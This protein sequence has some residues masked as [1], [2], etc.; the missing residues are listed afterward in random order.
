MIT[1]IEYPPC[2][3]C[4]KAK[5]WLNDESVSFM[6]RHIVNDTPSYDELKQWIVYSKLP[7]KA[8]F[9]TSGNVYKSL[10][11]KDK[12]VNMDDDEKILLLSQNGML[13]KRPILVDQTHVIVGYSEEKYSKYFKKA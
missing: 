6:A 4:K 3:T 8:F 11:L 9:N 7:V 10:N 13:I 1:F 5:K 12:L 2:S